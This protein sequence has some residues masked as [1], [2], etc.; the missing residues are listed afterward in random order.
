AGEAQDAD[1]TAPYEKIVA[2]SILD[3]FRRVVVEELAG[4]PGE[5]IVFTAATAGFILNNLLNAAQ[6][7]GAATGITWNFTN[8]HDSNG[9]PWALQL[10]RIEYKLGLKYIDLM[11]NLVDQGL[12]EI[13]FNGY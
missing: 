9:Q 8:T 2:P 10:P 4:G 12:M 1:P 13:R 3:M 5:S 11:R 7:R 6:A